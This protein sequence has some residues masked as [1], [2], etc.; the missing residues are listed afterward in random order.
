MWCSAVMSAFAHIRRARYWP[1]Y[2]IA[3]LV[4]AIGLAGLVATTQPL[5]G[6]NPVETPAAVSLEET[7]ALFGLAALCRYNAE[8]GQSDGGP[9]KSVCSHCTTIAVAV[10]ALLHMVLSLPSRRQSGPCPVAG[11]APRLLARSL[12]HPPRAPPHPCA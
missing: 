4:L 6:S 10:L 9:L 1:R 3:S 7:V 2:L 12:R 8:A 5:Q 11:S